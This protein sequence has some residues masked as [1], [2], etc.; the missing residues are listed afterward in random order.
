MTPLLR[1]EALDRRIADLQLGQPSLAA[2]V[3]PQLLRQR[4]FG[5]L[6]SFWD[7][8]DSPGNSRRQQLQQIRREQLLAEVQL[9]LADQ[10]LSDAHLFLLRTC[11]A[12]PLAW[13][14]EHLPAGQRAQLYRPLFSTRSP[15]RRLYLPAALVL[16]AD[17][18][19]GADAVPEQATGKALLCTI[20]HGIEAFASLAELHVELCERLDDPLQSQPL[21]SMIPDSADHWLIQQADRLRYDWFA[22]DLVEYQVRGL[23]DAQHQR[24]SAA[25]QTAWQRQEQPLDVALADAFDLVGPMD[26]K[27]ALST[28]YALLLEKHL[29]NWLRNTSPQGMAHIMQTAQELAG[30]LELAAAPGI[31]TF[32]QFSQRHTLLAWTRERLGQYLRHD[33]GIFNDPQDIRISVTLARRKGALLNP[34][35]PSSYI[36][37]ASRP[38]TGD[39]IELVAVTYRLD[40]LALLNIAWFDVDYWL[41]ARV[42]RD[43]GAE[44]AALLPEKVKALVRKLDVGS[45]YLRYVRTH[46]LDSAE[47]R[48]RLEAH[49]RINRARMHAEAA[50][51]RYA[52]HFLPGAL[53]QGYRWARAVVLY[54]DSSWRPTIDEHRIVVRQLIIDGHTLEGVLLLNAE[55]ASVQSLVVYTPDAPDRRPWREFRNTRELLRTLRASQALRQYLVQRLPLA[56]GK[57]VDKLLRQGRL[58]PYVQRSVI[59]GDLYAACYQAEVRSLIAQADNNSRSGREMLGESVI[60]AGHLLL[61]VISL[62]LPVPAK[63]ALAFGRMSISIFEAWESLNKNDGEACMQHMIA[64]LNHTSDGLSSFSGST[65]M[66]R[67]LR[68]LPSRPPQPLPE[69][70]QAIISLKTLRYRLEGVHGEEMYEQTHP[71]PGQTR[72][73]VKDRQGRLYNVTFDGHR[74]RISD[75]RQPDAYLQLPLKRRVDGDWV[76]DSPVLWYDGLPDL[77]QLF[78]A[79]RLQPALAGKAVEDEPDLFDADGQLYLLL[80]GRQLPVRRHLLSNHYH[81]RIADAQLASVQAWAVL[82]R[83]E[84]SW[85]IRVRQTGRS[86]AWL[87]VGS[88]A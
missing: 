57:H 77:Q 64:A 31:L 60:N 69:S 17:G 58:G 74:W 20:S 34:L 12:L 5:D 76:V 54:P 19:Q 24:L 59:G 45:G 1:L 87:A 62:V 83:Q 32:E 40:E 21:L 6:A 80:E 65:V 66:R 70:Q 28:R 81:L 39:T 73:F 55:V 79:S 51:A 85:H 78:E 33:P 27:H 47:G 8:T 43:D 67:A 53:E 2:D 36:A 46:L 56:D 61:D 3:T 42:H 26:S 52:K 35:V 86:S 50:K 41:T 30:A 14:R 4:F 82:R 15:Q 88:V 10:T 49:A 18:P 11:L 23:I 13:Q 29:P 72:Y 68:G 71:K 48:W 75:P 9:R 84:D 16:V 44:I 7:E 38:I 22:E 63:S 25:W 37:A